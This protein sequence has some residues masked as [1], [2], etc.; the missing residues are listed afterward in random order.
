MAAPFWSDQRFILRISAWPAVPHTS[1]SWKDLCAGVWIFTKSGEDIVSAAVTA[2]WLKSRMGSGHATQAEAFDIWC[3]TDVV[4]TSAPPP[5]TC[6]S[7]LSP[8]DRE[9][10]ISPQNLKFTR[11]RR[12]MANDINICLNYSSFSNF[13]SVIISKQK[14]IYSEMN[15]TTLDSPVIVH[16]IYLFFI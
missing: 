14:N 8:T 15:V 5:S 16:I 7:Y 12:K 9:A 11:K 6:W 1:Q 2:S 4:M 3:V 13:G 10:W